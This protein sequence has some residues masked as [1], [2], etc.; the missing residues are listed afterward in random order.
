MS[1]QCGECGKSMFEECRCG[2][3]E[4]DYSN[5]SGTSL[6]RDGFIHVIVFY[7]LLIGGLLMGL[8]LTK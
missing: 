3:P 4:Y 2:R 8:I 5:Y 1:I 6:V 7:L